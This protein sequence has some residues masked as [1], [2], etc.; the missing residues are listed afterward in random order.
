MNGATNNAAWVSLTF[1]D[2]LPQHLDHAAPV[3]E[4][5]GLLATFYC[6]LSAATL[7]DRAAD[8]RRLASVGHELGNHTAL[9]PAISSKSWVREGNAI[10]RYSLDRMDQEITLANQWLAS[11]D[12]KRER[13]FA[14]PC[15]NSFVGGHGYPRRLLRRAGWDRTRLAGWTDRLGLDWGRSR[16]SYAPVV[17]RHCVAARGG[18]LEIQS[19]PPMMG[20]VDRWHIPSA[21][22]AGNSLEEIQQFVCRGMRPGMWTILQFHGVGGGHAMDCARS[23]F[24][25]FC[26]WL[27]EQPIEV[28]TILTGAQRLWRE[29]V[30]A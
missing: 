29:P 18:G 16:V 9:H 19:T 8:W 14:Y 4:E 13:T 28:L 6:H 12:G 20:Q 30:H 27:V 21:A 7:S 10:E 17:S 15:S 23:V 2:A 26:R 22:V 1:D 5:C 3:L 24:V 11:I 25:E